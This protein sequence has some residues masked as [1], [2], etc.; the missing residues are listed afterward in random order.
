MHPNAGYIDKPT[1]SLEGDAPLSPQPSVAAAEREPV[2]ALAE[3]RKPFRANAHAPDHP[4]RLL[5]DAGILDVRICE[6]LNPPG[7][8]IHAHASTGSRIGK[9]DTKPLLVD[10]SDARNRNDLAELHAMNGSGCA[11]PRG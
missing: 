2:D 10:A 6:V 5:D 7:N 4:D 11:G 9:A 8:R 3:A 1:V